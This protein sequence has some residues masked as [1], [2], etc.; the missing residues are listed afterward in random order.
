[1]THEIDVPNPSEFDEYQLGGPEKRGK[2][3]IKVKGLTIVPERS[4]AQ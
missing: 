1:M 2:D 4:I 3:L